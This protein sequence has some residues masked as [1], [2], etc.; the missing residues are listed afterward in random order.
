M[1][2][3]TTLRAAVAAGFLTVDGDGKYSQ[4]AP[5]QL[6][7]RPPSSSSNSKRATSLP[8]F[9]TSLVLHIRSLGR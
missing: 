1:A 2:T 6:R 9:L 7:P 8:R 4:P 3:R 5:L